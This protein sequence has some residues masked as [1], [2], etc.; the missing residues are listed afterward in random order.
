MRSVHVQ[1]PLQR[2]ISGI[3]DRQELHKR[4]EAAVLLIRYDLLLESN[5]TRLYYELR[6]NHTARDHF[7]K[8]VISDEVFE[9]ER[10]DEL[11]VA[12]LCWLEDQVEGE[13]RFGVYFYPLHTLLP[14]HSILD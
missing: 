8:R 1:F 14:S 7:T 13:G 12:C 10:E 6:L 4:M 2:T 5:H 11:V 9:E 3:A